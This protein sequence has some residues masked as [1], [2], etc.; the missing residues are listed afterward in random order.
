MGQGCHDGHLGRVETL[1]GHRHRDE[2]GGLGQQPESGQGLVRV[3][4]GGGGEADI[5]RGPRH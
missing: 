2:D 4:F 3:A 1:V 5:I